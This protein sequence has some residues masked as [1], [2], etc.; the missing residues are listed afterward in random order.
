MV[1][2][3][4][5]RSNATN[6]LVQLSSLLVFLGCTQAADRREEV[7]LGTG[8]T[9]SLSFEERGIAQPQQ[10]YQSFGRTH[11]GFT[12][13]TIVPTA[14]AY[15]QRP[16][17]S[18][19]P[20]SIRPQARSTTQPCDA[21]RA[22]VGKVHSQ[23]AYSEE[24]PPRQYAAQPV[25]QN[26][27]SQ[28]QTLE[29][30]TEPKA[31][32][33]FLLQPTEAAGIGILN[34]EHRLNVVSQQQ[35]FIETSS[36]QFPRTMPE[37]RSQYDH[38]QPLIDFS[39][40]SAFQSRPKLV[41][42][43]YLEQASCQQELTPEEAAEA[44]L[45]SMEDILQRAMHMRN[46]ILGKQYE[47][48]QMKKLVDILYY[49]S[50]AE[51]LEADATYLQILHHYF[52][53]KESCGFYVP[54]QAKEDLIHMI[55]L[56][57]QATNRVDEYK[58]HLKLTSAQ[59]DRDDNSAFVGDDKIDISYSEELMKDFRRSMDQFN[60]YAT[61]CVFKE[62]LCDFARESSCAIQGLRTDIVNFIKNGDVPLVDVPVPTESVDDAAKTTCQSAETHGIQANTTPFQQIY[63]MTEVFVDKVFKILN[64][65]TL[66]PPEACDSDA[67]VR[68]P[69]FNVQ[70]F[71]P[72][73]KNDARNATLPSSA[74]KAQPTGTAKRNVRFGM[75]AT[76]SQVYEDVMQALSSFGPSRTQSEAQ[77]RP[78]TAEK[79]VPTRMVQQEMYGR[80][81]E[82]SSSSKSK[83]NRVGSGSFSSVKYA[84]ERAAEEKKTEG[85]HK[86]NSGMRS[87][88]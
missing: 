86:S 38:Q 27:K 40:E 69:H 72:R 45:K 79:S 30:A 1:S 88:R 22:P 20:Q 48:Y 73:T 39:D 37:S 84:Y 15:T 41:R 46:F 8:W 68:I 33:V 49:G 82:F 63:D 14:P 81:P 59:E 24:L 42:S 25:P 28:Q 6:L 76:P 3:I 74:S 53:I 52:A 44:G 5:N 83:G 47:V 58:K 57:I 31:P 62:I 10:Q 43:D 9:P 64:E 78:P 80:Q 50:V 17:M 85:K 29:R 7:P 77:Q 11:P 21:R 51:K 71:V 16:N 2:F 70:P 13:E 26:P 67:Q 56:N 75:R 55:R 19:P 18:M 4:R 12:F 65:R 23:F 87:M 32:Q 34:P 61:D 35:D 36:N 60:F 66:I 54:E